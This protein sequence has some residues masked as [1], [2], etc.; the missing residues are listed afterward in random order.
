M[1][2]WFSLAVMILAWSQMPPSQDP[3]SLPNWLAS[4]MVRT[5]WL[6]LRLVLSYNI[7]DILTINPRVVNLRKI[8]VSKF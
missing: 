5:H 2:A 3:V 6:A 4:F 8:E 1:I 7:L